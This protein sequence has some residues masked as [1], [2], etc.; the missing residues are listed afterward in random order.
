MNEPNDFLDDLAAGNDPLDRN[1]AAALRSWRDSNHDSTVVPD[2]RLETRF[3]QEPPVP[4]PARW[5]Q[6]MQRPAI[7]FAASFAA[8]LILGAGAFALVARDS[9]AEDIAAS[10]SSIASLAAVDEDPAEITLPSDLTD[11]TDYGRCVLGELTAWFTGGFS[12]DDAPRLTDTCGLPPIPDL[13][14]EA[15][16]FR[17]DLQAW[18]VCVAGEIDAVLP[19]LPKLLEQGHDDLDGLADIENKCGEP[20]DPRDY[21]L[22]LPFADFDWESFDPSQFNFGTFNLNDLNLE[23]FDLE[24]LMDKLPDGVLPEDVDIEQWRSHF[25]D[26]DLEG[27]KLD[28]EACDPA[29]FPEL[30]DVESLEDLEGIDFKAWFEDLDGSKLCGLA[31]F[32]NP[33]DLGELDLEQLLSDLEGLN[34]TELLDGMF[35]DGELDLDVLLESF[36]EQDV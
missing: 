19:E 36:T 12:G 6:W 8:V 35:G 13:G 33:D 20:P 10:T 24:G 32:F 9:S 17:S 34:L 4:E 28:L 16:A 3:S 2:E 23:G 7:A 21:G 18:S 25:G 22:Q 5:R 27:F 31:G 29:D 15:E 26:F 11:Q 14:P 1:L 30:G